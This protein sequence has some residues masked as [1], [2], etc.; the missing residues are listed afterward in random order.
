MYNVI[1]KARRILNNHPEITTYEEFEKYI[2]SECME[3][4]QKE[5]PAHKRELT[6][7]IEARSV[8]LDACGFQETKERTLPSKRGISGCSMTREIPTEFLN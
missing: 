5:A 6:T 1:L 4:M 3:R 2:R 7:L 8:A